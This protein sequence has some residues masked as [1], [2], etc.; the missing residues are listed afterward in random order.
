MLDQTHPVDSL[1]QDPK[2]KGLENKMS[3]QPPPPDQVT[4]NSLWKWIVI[5]FLLVI[6]GSAI[7]LAIL[8]T[9]QIV[10]GD[11]YIIKGETILTIFT[12]AVGFI[13]GLLSPSPVQK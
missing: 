9:K 13:A 1:V 2:Q 6:V 8:S 11:T 3:S 10:D 4:A 5:T 7:M 12:T